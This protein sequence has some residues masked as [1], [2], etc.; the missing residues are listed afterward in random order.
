MYF[1]IKIIFFCFPSKEKIS[2]FLEKKKYH[3][4]R[5]YKKEHVQA[6]FFWKDHLFRTFEENILFPGTSLRK[7]MFPF[8]SKE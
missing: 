5:Y 6:Q 1:L 3:L 8:A 2:Y 4:S 7:I